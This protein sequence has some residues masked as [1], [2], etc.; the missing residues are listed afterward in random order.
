MFAGRVV[1]ILPFPVRDALPES[2]Q[3]TGKEYEVNKP[4]QT[5]A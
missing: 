4:K 3:E 1:H 5:V 2:L